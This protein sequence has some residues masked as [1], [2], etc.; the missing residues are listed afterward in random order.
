MTASFFKGAVFRFRA[1]GSCY[2]L[3]KTGMIVK[4]KN[5]R[6]VL[7][8]KGVEILLS[9][10]GVERVDLLLRVLYNSKGNNMLSFKLS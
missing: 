2:Q 1:R 5:K 8:F 6:G 7:L 3:N 9:T 4:G 10:I